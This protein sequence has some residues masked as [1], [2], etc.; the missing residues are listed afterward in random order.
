MSEAALMVLAVLVLFVF[1]TMATL[2]AVVSMFKR[3]HTLA[4]ACLESQRF[5]TP[6]PVVDAEEKPEKVIDGRPHWP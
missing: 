5:Y 3:M 1:Q 4:E 2:V 6:P